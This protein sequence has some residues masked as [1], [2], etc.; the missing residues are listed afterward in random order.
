MIGHS[1]FQRPQIVLV[2]RIRAF[3][4]SLKNLH[5]RVFFFQIPLEIV[6]LSR[7]IIS[8][9]LEMSNLEAD[10]DFG[11]LTVVLSGGSRILV[12]GGGCRWR[13]HFFFCRFESLKTRL[14]WFSWRVF[15]QNCLSFG[16]YFIIYLAFGANLRSCKIYQNLCWHLALAEINQ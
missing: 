1:I 6:L 15:L 9:Y 10:P 14:L 7:Y 13:M 12:W 2:L 16:K 8:Y 3:L 4:R 11:A 5:V